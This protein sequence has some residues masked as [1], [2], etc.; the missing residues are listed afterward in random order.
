M[1]Y[2]QDNKDNSTPIGRDPLDIQLKVKLYWQLKNQVYLDLN[3]KMEW[4]FTM[5]ND[6]LG[7]HLKW[8]LNEILSR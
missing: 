8:I 4:H 7:G 2:L 5:L 3:S 1:K 6:Q